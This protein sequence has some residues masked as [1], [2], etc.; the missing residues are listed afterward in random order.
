M[1]RD[2]DDEGLEAVRLRIE[3]EL[4]EAMAKA[5]AALSEESLWKA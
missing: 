3:S 2:L 1:P 5:E 4:N